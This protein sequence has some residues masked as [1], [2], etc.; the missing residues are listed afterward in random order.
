MLLDLLLVASLGLAP[1]GVSQDD[2]FT[3][4]VEAYRRGSY[5]EADAH[6]QACLGRSLDDVE[7]ARVAFDL[8]NAAWRREQVLVAVGWYTLAVELAPRDPDAWHN[9]E[10]ARA[11]AGLEPAD[12]GDLS[13]TLD[14][15]S[16]SLRPEEARLL[17]LAGLG[18]LALVLL[19]EALR[20][21]RVWR[22][23]SLCA[24]VLCLLAAVPW[25]RT[26]E[27]RDAG[28]RFLVVRAP[29]AALRSE[30]KLALESI[31]S[32]DAGTEVRRIDRLPGWVRVRTE[33]GV[34]G[35]LQEDALFALDRG[36]PA[37]APTSA[38]DGS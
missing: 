7:R 36:A 30:P 16:S 9:L 35:W 15:I 2:S 23:L 26:L 20:G 5:A 18:L 10:L 34:R 12:R 14:R 24:L 6:W 27:G 33:D 3:L 29:A 1:P 8:G 4:G 21:G 28:E 32:V 13:A 11:K 25:L 31:A 37:A 19:G 17:A 38:A 22:R